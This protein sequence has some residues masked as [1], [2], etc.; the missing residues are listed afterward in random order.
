M[1]YTN[2][3]R[4]TIELLFSAKIVISFYFLKMLDNQQRLWYN[5]MTMRKSN[6]IAAFNYNGA[7]SHNRLWSGNFYSTHT[8]KSV[9]WFVFPYWSYCW[10]TVIRNSRWENLTKEIF[11]WQY[12]GN[13][14]PVIFSPG[15]GMLFAGNIAVWCRVLGPG[16]MSNLVF[17]DKMRKT[18]KTPVCSRRSAFGNRRYSTSWS[19]MVNIW[20][21][22]F[23]ITHT[24]KSVVWPFSPIYWS[25]A[26]KNGVRNS[27]WSRE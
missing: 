3:W 25:I 18:N 12:D 9:V 13:L 8:Y 21:K 6:K 27:R 5:I 17:G 14:S 4:E 16:V 7:F 24:Y 2:F 22:N 1:N 26:W 15:H 10:K 11:C 23:C 19:G 20:V